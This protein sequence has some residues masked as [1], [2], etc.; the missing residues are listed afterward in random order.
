[1][2]STATASLGLYDA[3][4]LSIQNEYWL[5]SIKYIKQFRQHYPNHKLSTDVTKK[6]SVAY[7]NSKQ[8]IAAAQELEKLSGNDE[9]LEYKMASLL[10][11][12]QLYQNN[13]EYT[14]AIRAY[15]DYVKHYPKP[16]ADY[17]ESLYQLTILNQQIKKNKKSLV[18][19]KKIFSV[20]K[21]M[22]NSIKNSRSNFIA[23][24]AAMALARD[25]NHAFSRVKLKKPLKKNLKLKKKTMQTSVNYYAKASS[26]GIAETATEATYS[27]AK[28]YNDFSQSLLNSEIPKHLDED[29][30]EQYTFLLEDQA[31]PF[32]EKAIEFYEVNMRYTNDDI[33]D[34]WIIKS[35]QQLQALF[36]LRYKRSAKVEEVI[37]VL[38]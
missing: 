8:D 28:I 16:F 11:A 34:Q 25:N 22:P 5:Q 21:Q 37:N 19:Q 36:P 9:S 17:I 29:Q 31:F 1:M 6:L 7:L 18:W 33:Y 10:K 3:I 30:R 20:D 32:E 24:N 35:L 26:Y 12:A 27:I 15:E 38:H 14:S 13:K 4:A 2:P 23:S